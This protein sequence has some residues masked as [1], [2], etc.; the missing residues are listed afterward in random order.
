MGQVGLSTMPGKAGHSDKKGEALLNYV[1]ENVIGSE[2]AFDGPFG[3]RPV[4]Y[5]DYTASGRPLQ[6]IEDYITDYVYPTYGNTHTTTSIVSL[7]TTKFRNSARDIIKKCVNAS[8]D[9][10]VIFVGSGT[11]GAVHKL[12][13][14]LGLQTDLFDET[15]T[16]VFVGPYEHHSNILPWKENGLKVERIREDKDGL[17][18]VDYLTKLLKEYKAKQYTMIGAFSASS[19][20][21]G[22]LTDTVAVAEILHEYGA[23]SF[24]DYAAG[25]PYLKIDMNPTSTGYKDAVF[26]S[27]HKFIGGVGTPGLLIAKKWL[28]TNSVPHNCGGGTVSYVT[29]ETHTYLNDIEE[30]EE[31]GTPAIVESIRC[32]MVFQLKNAIGADFIERKEAELCQMAYRVW[33]RNPNILLLGN[34]SVPRV[35]ILSFLVLNPE[36]GKFLHHNFVSMLL[37]DLYGIQTRGGCAC[38]GPYAQDLLEMDEEMAQR[39]AVFFA[40]RGKNGE[41]TEPQE[42]MKPGFARLNLP[43]FFEDYTV[44]F[45]LEAVNQVARHGWKLLPLYHLDVKTGTC[46]HRLHTY[47][48]QSLFD[49]E[50]K[51]TGMEVKS[52]GITRNMCVTK[53]ELKDVL[54]KAE[55]VF[56]KASKLCRVINCTYDQEIKIL[57][58]E[59]HFVWFLQPRDAQMMLFGPR[60]EVHIKTAAS[61]ALGLPFYPKRYSGGHESEKEDKRRVESLGNISADSGV[62]FNDVPE[63]YIYDVPRRFVRDDP[64][65]G[66]LIQP[67]SAIWSQNPPFSRTQPRDHRIYTKKNP[68]Y[69]GEDAYAVMHSP[70]H[71]RLSKG[72]HYSSHGDLPRAGRLAT[73]DSLGNNAYGSTMQL[74]SDPRW[75]REVNGKELRNLDK[76]GGKYQRKGKRDSGGMVLQDPPYRAYTAQ[77]LDVNQIYYS[78]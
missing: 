34:K 25:A 78:T 72:A 15:N 28:F 33:S 21:T 11:T 1:R 55:K 38:A 17:F 71:H 32:G 59:R 9:D 61:R 57:P 53:E 30:R 60:R 27:P 22:I 64:Q 68:L 3:S 40:E 24:W 26:C 76:K 4:T 23:L 36:S 35:P 10:V 75:R 7:Q 65:V 49:I 29:R 73:Y 16:V 2:V 39:F 70:H 14:V 67:S 66:E 63:D 54:K 48:M 69:V 8:E 47:S 42:I 46:K 74:Y 43:Y 56:A 18:D 45:V 52:D 12:L 5:C 6:F 31:G 13:N 51:M 77:W 37:N 50:Y 62:E 19:N 44:K 20:V 58:E 41:I